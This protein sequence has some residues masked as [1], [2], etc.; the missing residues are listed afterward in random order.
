MKV[1]AAPGLTVPKEDN[2]RS[3]IT[4]DE[5]QEVP[6]SY[7]YLRRVSDGDLVIVPDVAMVPDT[8]KDVKVKDKSAASNT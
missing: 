6:E 8:V 7:Y 2:P 3:Y 5:A 1:C 4:Q